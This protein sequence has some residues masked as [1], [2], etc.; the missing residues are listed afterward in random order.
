MN[1][2]STLDKSERIF[3][4]LSQNGLDRIAKMQNLS[5]NEFK[6]ITK[7]SSLL[8]NEQEQITKMRRIKNCKNMS[9]KELLIA[10]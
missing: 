6:Q 7:M 10:L 9:R 5:Q 1:V 4:D 2:L 3:K 8:Q